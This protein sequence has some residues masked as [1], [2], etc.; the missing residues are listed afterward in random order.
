MADFYSISRRKADSRE[1]AY[2]FVGPGGNILN[3][4]MALA[5]V[6]DFKLTHVCEPGNE[7]A[8]PARNYAFEAN[9]ETALAGSDIVLTDSLREEFRHEAYIRHYQITL[10]RMKLARP[11]AL[12]NPCPPFFRG[13]EVAE[14]VI[15]S[16][17]F[18]GYAFKKDLLYVHQ[19]IVLY[20]LR[21]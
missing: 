7:Q 9:L 8:E 20:C 12:L 13:E 15:D 14:D 17:F 21:N 3:S 11:G 6:M 4:W 19:A 10:D 1:L 18:A 16:D 2:T 5:R